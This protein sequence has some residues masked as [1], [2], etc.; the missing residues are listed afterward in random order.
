LYSIREEKYRKEGKTRFLEQPEKAMNVRTWKGMKKQ[1]LSLEI[2][3][4]QE[5][6][7]SIPISSTRIIKG[8]A[9]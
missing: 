8:L 5:V 6:V 2:H 1:M 3:G 7:G 9:G 4:I